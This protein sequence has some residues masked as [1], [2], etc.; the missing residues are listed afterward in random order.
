MNQSAQG[1]SPDASANNTAKR[2]RGRPRKYPKLISEGNTRIPKIQRNENASGPPGF[3]G[4]N[5][6]QPRPAA[7]SVDT[8]N[9]MLGKAVS[10][11][12]EAVFDA[13]YLLC[14]K[15]ANTDVTLR[16]VVFKP[17]RF[18]PVTAEN[19]VAPNLQMI[20]RNEVPIPTEHH[21]PRPRERKEQQ[22]NPRRGW[23]HSF[24]E[25]P[26]ANQVP[27]VPSYPANNVVPKGKLVSS[28]VVQTAHPDP[29]GSRGNLVPV[30][31]EPAKVLNGLPLAS[32]PTPL[33]SQASHVAASKGKQ[34]QE[35]AN[36]LNG[37]ISTTQVPTFGSQ[38]VL[39]QL[40]DTHQLVSEVAENKNGAYV[41]APTEK[42][43]VAEAKSMS[44]PDVPFEKL[45]SEVV[46]RVEV[47]SE[48]AESQFGNSKPAV[49]T[50]MKDENGANDV[51]QALVI[52]PLQAVKP[53]EKINP[54]SAPKSEENEK[55]SKMSQL[56]EVLQGNVTE[57]RVLQ[58]EEPAKDSA[59][60]LG[61]TA[62]MITDQEGK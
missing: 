29:V 11:V 1:N 18:V 55:T 60:K 20:R 7:A 58:D 36:P 26:M 22:A 25:T 10:G 9:S 21:N 50:S 23:A 30:V 31:L 17:G 27:R 59:H 8:N 61:K 49:K 57:T 33:A 40:Q 48:S 3:G 24:S 51:D 14:V 53:N 4:V 38:A 44:L 15:V 43:E 5:G 34:A 19:D 39:S 37:S 28:V 52:E 16:G 2:K 13:G 35:A 12:I 46:K 6:N 62:S 42:L 56:L 32:E 54:V 45:V 47:P 41:Q